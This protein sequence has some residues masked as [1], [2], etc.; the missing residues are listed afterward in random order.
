MRNTVSSHIAR[1]K[2]L[3]EIR[4]R[5]VENHGASLA[6]VSEEG[7]KKIDDSSPLALRWVGPAT[8]KN[9]PDISP[10]QDKKIPTVHELIKQGALVRSAARDFGA[11]SKG[12]ELSP[13]QDAN[14]AQ[15]AD[16]SIVMVDGASIV[17]MEKQAHALEAVRRSLQRGQASLQK[18]VTLPDGS[19]ANPIAF[20]PTFN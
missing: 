13:L 4:R 18:P 11:G 20:T 2:T 19:K 15:R 7:G 14:L 17:S 10:V 16:G 1:L 3:E 6:I 8:G 5:R 12:Y 9:T